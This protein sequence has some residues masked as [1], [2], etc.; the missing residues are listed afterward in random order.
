MSELGVQMS[1]QILLDRERIHSLRCKTVALRLTGIDIAGMANTN[2]C[3]GR[4]FLALH[5]ELNT[6]TMCYCNSA[7]Q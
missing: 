3:N 5:A 2:S 4:C 7:S 6:T 1:V